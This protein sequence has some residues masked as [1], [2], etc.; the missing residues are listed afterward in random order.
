MRGDGFANIL[1]DLSILKENEISYSWNTLRV[2]KKYDLL[3]SAQIEEYA[4]QY[5]SEHPQETSQFIVD[6][7]CYDKAMPID[8]I[9]NKVADTIDGKIN[10]DT[11]KWEL[12]KRKLRYC[13]LVY[14]KNHIS[15]TR[16]LLDKI[17][18][19]YDDFGFPEDMEDFI[20]YMPAKKFNPLK[21]SEKE[22]VD[23]LVRLFEIFLINEQKFLSNHR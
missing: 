5:L 18:L 17:A 19:V 14:L 3:D 13:V 8:D 20:Y 12:E 15:D 7:A 16:E 9:L 10:I 21:Y 6:L 4:T 1:C 22:C 23:R 2:G 11:P